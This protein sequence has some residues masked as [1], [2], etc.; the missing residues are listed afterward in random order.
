MRITALPGLLL[1]LLV[2]FATGLATPLA[3]DAATSASQQTSQKN[4]PSPKSTTPKTQVALA[5]HRTSSKTPPKKTTKKSS[6]KVDDRP[7]YRHA[8]VVDASN[9][10]VL[11]EEHAHEPADPASIVKMMVTLLTLEQVELGTIS[12]DDTIEV[13]DRAARIGGHQVYLKTG[14]VFTLE[15]LLKA[16]MITS[17]NDAAFAV[18][19]YVAGSQQAFVGLMN[20]RAAQLGMTDTRFVNAHGLP[21]E[22]RRFEDS[23]QTSAY[24][25]TLLARELLDRF[26]LVLQWTSSQDETFRD[27]PLINTNH[28]LLDNFPGVDGLKTGYHRGAGFNLVATATRDGRRIISV[29]MGAK[30]K[31]ER[32]KATMHLLDLGFTTIQTAQV[33]Q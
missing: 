19:E 6:S 21:P 29:V 28:S 10:A 4:T 26:P 3:A 33:Q 27:S 1:C 2:A 23:N 15:Q 12:L 13:T 5:T 14:E 7:P 24:D 17:A 20:E 18:A 9:G 16:V 31:G 32:L 11:Y 8:I 22:N 25:L 30:N